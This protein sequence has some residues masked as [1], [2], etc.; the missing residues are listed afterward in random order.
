MSRD[1]SL[2]KRNSSG[3]PGS[4]PPNTAAPPFDKTD[5]SQPSGY[6]QNEIPKPPGTVKE[7]NIPSPKPYLF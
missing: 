5:A 3:Y 7:E 2:F 6:P 4:P 1:N